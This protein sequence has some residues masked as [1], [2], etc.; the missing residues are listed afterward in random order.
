[1]T[2]DASPTLNTDALRDAL[3]RHVDAEVR[4]DDAHRA[5]YALDASKYYQTP[6]GAVIPRTT[7][8]LVALVNICREHNAPILM[9]GAGTSL[10]GQTCNHA[11]VVDTTRYLNRILDLDP[12]AKL[13]RVQPGVVL[14]TLRIAAEKHGL[15]FGPDPS[16]HA[17]CTLGGMIGNNACGVHSVMAGRTVD[18]VHAMDVITYDGHRMSVGRTTDEQLAKLVSAGGK[19]GQ[20]YADLRRLRDRYADLI[21]ERYPQIPRRVSGY[22]LDELLPEKG[23]HVARALTGTEGTCAVML[24]ATVHLVPSPPMRTLLVLGFGDVA[25][26]ADRVPELL[27]YK[28]ISL[29]GMDSLLLRCIREKGIEPVGL[30]HLPPGNAWLFVE[31]GADTQHQANDQA[32]RV[33]DVV[34]AWRLPGV[35]LIEEKHVRDSVA[36]A[37]AAAAGANA[38]LADGR[39]TWEGWEDCAVHPSQLGN[40]IRDYQKLLTKY[41]RLG[42]IYGHFGDGLVHSRIDFEMTTPKG[43]AQ[44]RQFVEEGADLVVRYHGSLTGEHGDGQSRAELLPKMFGA[45]LVQAFAEFK[46]IWDPHNRMNPGKIVDPRKLDDDLRIGAQYKLPQLTT[47]F[48]F[49]DDQNNFGRAVARCTGVGKCR[50][51]KGAV[52]CPSWRV[53]HEEMHT[54][55]GRAHLLFDMTEGKLPGASGWQSEEVKAALD[56]CLAC[57]GC[58]R[59]C[60]TGTDMATY[61]A[62]FLSHYFEHKRR[63]VAAYSMGLIHRFAPLASRLAPIV[64]LLGRTP[65][66]SHLMKRLGGIAPQRQIPRFASRPFRSRFKQSSGGGGGKPPVILWADT[67]NNHLTPAIAEAAVTVL[68]AAGFH[69]IVPEQRLCCGRPLYD[70]GM[71]DE[72]KRLLTEILEALAPHIDA[73]VPVVALE[74][75]CGA[76]FRDELVN[77]FPR[78]PRAQKLKANTFMLAEFLAKNAPHFLVP[79]LRTAPAAAIYHGHCHQKSLVGVDHD[80]ALLR[81]MG[82]EVSTPESSCCGMAGSF[83]YE[84]EHYDISMK[85]AEQ[86]LLPA[87]RAAPAAILVADG[88]SCREQIAQATGRPVLHLAELLAAAIQHQSPT[89]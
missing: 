3:A 26:A 76:V 4:F 81:S 80:I 13:A 58:K 30:K 1:V 31:F 84:A 20:I 15:T 34:E 41:G 66:I 61:K 32:R 52:M 40:Y 62:E 51:E 67:F 14:D 38:R 77:L 45:E 12:S 7:E 50:S 23:F 18:N 49:P 53:T 9:R 86:K 70:Y 74:P 47:H 37:R 5:L 65:G 72:A 46:G 36:D 68:E 78:D 55:R 25:D 21:R 88:L 54:T 89:H 82:L 48:Q 69:V 71:L 75:S 63:P 79:R 73:G 28:P 16:T 85:I 10:A 60:P 35:V 6:L 64:N 39:D 19:T 87:V 42:T 24:E 17:W 57:K 27:T 22:N 59:D 8:A 2:R 56:L 33:M 29:E 43:V 44:Y 83:G 11:V